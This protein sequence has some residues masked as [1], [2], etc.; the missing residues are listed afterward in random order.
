MQ[1]KDW[2]G[3]KSDTQNN[4]QVVSNQQKPALSPKDFDLS[5]IINNYPSSLETRSKLAAI[6]HDLYP[7]EKYK[8]HIVLTVYESGVSNRIQ[9]ADKL[10][11]QLIGT[12]VHQLMDDYGMREDSSLQGIEIW[13]AAY[14]LE[15][16]SYNNNS[17]VDA[18]PKQPETL[19]TN[20]I[21]PVS[22]KKE[23]ISPVQGKLSEYDLE[24][25]KDSSIIIKKFLGFDTSEMVVPNI[26]DGKK[27]YGIGQKAYNH[28]QAMK[29]LTVSD[30]IRFIDEYA[31]YYCP[32]LKNVV[33]PES[34][35]RIARGAFCGCSSLESIAL[36][37]SIQCISDSLFYNCK[38]LKDITLGY[39]IKSLGNDAFC[40]CS[41][42]ES[43]TAPSTL[44]SIGLMA[45]YCCTSLKSVTLNEGL[46]TIGNSAFKGCVNLHKILIPSTV[47]WIGDNTFKNLDH[48]LHYGAKADIILYCY[49]GSKALAYAREN[50]YTVRNAANWPN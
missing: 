30:G 11:S 35:D 1:I 39:G 34:I 3:S 26:I 15:M 4:L 19:S 46:K 37:S 32:N 48:P 43:F 23:T 5:Y 25:L 2:F 9:S 10:T 16:P 44:E 27:I 41:A 7:T 24:V 42:L 22:I 13:S 50:G 17:T 20:V 49:S 40:N 33:L 31:I 36:P 38:S 14:H 18:L 12:F 21:S 28:C 8:T 45:F 6:L 47:E 29:N